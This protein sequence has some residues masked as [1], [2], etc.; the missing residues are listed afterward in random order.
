MTQKSYSTNPFSIIGLRSGRLTV[1]AL[2]CTSRSGRRQWLCRCDCGGFR[3]VPTSD[4]FRQSTVSCG[5]ILR[6]G[7]GYG[8]RHGEAG[9]HRGRGRTAEYVC[10]KGM[11]GRCMRS[12]DTS[13]SKYG[14]RGVGVCERWFDYFNFLSDMGRKPT[15]RHS[16]DRI[17]PDGDYEP[18]NCR[19]ATSSE[20]RKNQRKSFRPQP[21]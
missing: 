4:I 10:W 15:P 1:V 16:I 7:R 14:A 2:G 17:N 9:D 20:Q 3:C 11:I 18:D 5:C 21:E 19:W 6:V 12:S 13:W 8:R